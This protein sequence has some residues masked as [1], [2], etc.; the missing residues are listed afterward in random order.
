MEA[1]LAVEGGTFV[2]EQLWYPGLERSASKGYVSQHFRAAVP[3][4]T[5][6]TH[7]A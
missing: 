6:N 1:L 3:S 7:L 2:L 5:P 4:L